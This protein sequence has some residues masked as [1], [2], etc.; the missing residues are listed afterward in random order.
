MQCLTIL[1]MTEQVPYSVSMFCLAHQL[2]HS[3]GNS[4][5]RY[6]ILLILSTKR[7][8]WTARNVLVCSLSATYFT[9]GATL[10][11]PQFAAYKLYI[12]D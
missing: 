6:K 12:A 10:G 2:L 5:Y 1:Y 4:L 3:R 8:L 9:L 7:L 11:A